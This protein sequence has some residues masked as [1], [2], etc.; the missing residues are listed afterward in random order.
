MGNFLKVREDGLNPDYIVMPGDQVAVSTWG[1][2]E[3]NGVFPVDGQGNLFLPEIGPVH[4][5][6]VR[7]ADLTAAVE[8]HIGSVY[9]GEFGVYTNLL[10]A[11]PVAVFVTGGV[12]RPGRYAGIPSDSVLFFLDQAGGIDPETGSYRNIT[13]LR[14]GKPIAEIDLYD[15][16][17]RGKIDTP[18]LEDNDTILVNRR[19]PVVELRGDVAAPSLIE[20]ESRSAKGSEALEVVARQAR[21]TEVTVEGMRDGMPFS[22]TMSVQT[23]A[24]L[25]LENGDVVTVRS[26]YRPDSIL[27]HLEGEFDG[28]ST[29]SVR[30]GT[31]LLDVLNYVP[32]DP[33][34]ADVDSIHIKRRSVAKAQKE[35]IDDSLFRLERSAL[36]ALSATRGIADIRVKEAEMTRKFVEQAKLIQ[37]L[38]RV[39]TSRSGRQLN[40]LLEEQDV[41]VVPKKTNVVRVGGEVLMTQAVVFEP[42]SR[43][44]VYVAAAG[45]YSNRADEDK[46]IIL[47]PD[48][49][50]ELT[51]PRARVQPGDEVLVPP[52]IDRKTA[53]GFMDFTSVVYQLAYSAGVIVPIARL[54][55]R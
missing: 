31:R 30:R 17:L 40:V 49:S 16:V 45:G 8:K 10:T 39:V 54:A 52:R 13:L 27:V 2:V 7:N 23:F 9:R 12:E 28:P 5:V 47:H 43:A 51:T 15:F 29:L 53:Q 35:S 46:I 22:R 55:G 25:P 33:V 4:L 44:S 34:V 3:I 48:A 19:G 38:G 1:S 37:P 21:A 32:V 6:G 24:E 11:N 18:Q 14:K 42:G 50:V 20:F 36:L 41:I 26:D